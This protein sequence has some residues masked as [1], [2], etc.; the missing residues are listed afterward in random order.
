MAVDE[1]PI[2]ERTTEESGRFPQTWLEWFQSI[3]DDATGYTGSFTNGDGNT[4]TVVNG[5]IT[6]V[7]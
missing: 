4:V 6:D 2:Q 1:P 5:K 3:A 7:S